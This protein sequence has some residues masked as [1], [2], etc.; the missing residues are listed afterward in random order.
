MRSVTH[1]ARRA[2]KRLALARR[3]RNHAFTACSVHP[4]C[5]ANLARVAASGRLSNSYTPFRITSW[6]SVMPLCASRAASMRRAR[7]SLASRRRR[8]SASDVA[9]DDIDDVI[10]ARSPSTLD[11]DDGAAVVPRRIVARARSLARA[12]STTHVDDVT[13]IPRLFRNLPRAREPCA[14]RRRRRRRRRHT[15]TETRRRRIPLALD[16][17]DDASARHSD[18]LCVA[19]SR[20]TRQLASLSRARVTSHER[21]LARTRTNERAR[22]RLYASRVGVGDVDPR[23]LACVKD[24]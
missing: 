1:S 11:D 5:L 20:G 21:R 17:C 24:Q 16:A 13:Q 23:A 4:T 2:F 19:K 7:L 9:G 10:V 22:E 6:T 18:D 14:R 8:L 15:T 3:E 12:A